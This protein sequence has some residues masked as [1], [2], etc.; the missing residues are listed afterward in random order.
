M[1]CQIYDVV[2]ELNYEQILIMSDLSVASLP[3]RVM[4]DNSQDGGYE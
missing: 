2:A 1:V 4:S 3:T